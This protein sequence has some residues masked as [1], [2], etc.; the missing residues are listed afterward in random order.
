M[1]HL[2]VGSLKIF[3]HV[4]TA[5]GLSFQILKATG[6]VEVP[7]S[8]DVAVDLHLGAPAK[9]SCRRGGERFIGTALRG[10]VGI[11]PAK[12]SMKW[13]MSGDYFLL[14]LVSG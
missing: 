10:H 2:Q 5:S 6:V 8:E 12:V 11:V 3:A 13:E 1:G 9:M 14:L 4:Q 7:E